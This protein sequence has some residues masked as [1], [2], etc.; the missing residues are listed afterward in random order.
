MALALALTDIF[1]NLERQ[2]NFGERRV[3][4]NVASHQSTYVSFRKGRLQSS[5]GRWV[6]TEGTGRPYMMVFTVTEG[7]RG[8]QVT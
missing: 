2:L 5:Q 4:K 7:T 3:H 6:V 1:R 8:S